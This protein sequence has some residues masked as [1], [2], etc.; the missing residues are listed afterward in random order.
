MNRGVGR[1][2][3]AGPALKPEVL[4]SG[5]VSWSRKWTPQFSS[6]GAVI[7]YRGEHTIMPG[8][9]GSEEQYQ[10]AADPIKG[11]AVETE[12]A[13]HRGGTELSAGGGYYDWTYQGAQLSDSSRWLAVFKAIQH[14]GDWSV[15]GEARYVDGRQ[16]TDPTTG[17]LTQVPA[18]WTLRASA[19]R[20]WGWGWGQVSLED[21]TNSRRRDLVAPEYG[22]VTWM[23]GDGRAVNATLGVKF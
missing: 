8:T 2:H 23:E 4:T 17:I 21:L 3:P 6:H 13:W 19:R 11:T 10:N 5:Q 22:L 12:L 9:A 7:F 14:A 18:N 1:T 15:A 20:E 16:N